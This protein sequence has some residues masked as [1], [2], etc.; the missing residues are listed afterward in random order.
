MSNKYD[1]GHGEEFNKFFEFIRPSID[2]AITNFGASISEMSYTMV[3]YVRDHNREKGIKMP[4]S[5]QQE[6]M[7]HLSISCVNYLLSEINENDGESFR[8]FVLEKLNEERIKRSR[9]N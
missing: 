5:H 4:L 1:T 8:V 9:L 3:E 2:K 7:V 6:Y